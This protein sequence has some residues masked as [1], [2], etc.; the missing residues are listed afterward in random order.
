MRSGS[1]AGA[2]RFIVAGQIDL[3]RHGRGR[4]WVVHRVVPARDALTV[5]NGRRCTFLCSGS[6]AIPVPPRT[7][8]GRNAD[9]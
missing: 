8:Y 4:S 9:S 5:P 2:H 7:P 1:D 6:P 3:P